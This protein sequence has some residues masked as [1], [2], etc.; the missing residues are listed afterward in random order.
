MSSIKSVL[1]V[2][3][4]VAL[5]LLICLGCGKQPAPV[6]NV[7]LLEKTEDATSYVY[8]TVYD[9]GWAE[10][11]VSFTQ[12]DTAEFYTAVHDDFKAE[13]VSNKLKITLQNTLLNS[14][15]LYTSP[16]PRDA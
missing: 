4:P 9:N 1:V 6:L 12:D 16:S 8:Y 3:I 10:K 14:C 13:I 11:T 15:L 5:C 7:A 2:V